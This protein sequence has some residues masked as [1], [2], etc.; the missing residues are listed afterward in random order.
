MPNI[1]P[2]ADE[3]TPSLAQY[4]SWINHTNE[5]PTE[6]QTLA[7]LAFFKWMHE[8]YGMKLDIYAFDAGALDGCKFY[9][10]LESERFKRQFPNGLKPIVDAAASFGCRLGIWGGPDGF[11]D[12]EEEARER[13]QTMVS[14][15]RDHN[16][17]LFKFDSVCGALRPEKVK[18]FIEMMTECRKASPD[19][20]LLNHR[21]ELGEGLPHATTFLWEGMEMYT[22]VHTTNPVPATHNRVGEISRGLPPELKRLTE[23]HGVC[24]SSCVDFWEDSLI[25]QAFNRGLILAP[26]IYG[27]PWL[28][29]DDEFPRLARIYNL[30]HRYRTIL[31]QGQILSKDTY[32]DDAISRGDEKT[33]FLSLRNL[34]WEI[35]ML[36]VT[37]NDSIGLAKGDHVELR[38]MHPFEEVLGTYSWGETIEVRVEPFRACLLI[39]STNNIDEIGF[40]GC[41]GEIICDLPQKDAELILWGEPGTEVK[42]RINAKGYSGAT[43]E[44]EPANDLLKEGLTITFPGQ[45]LNDDYHRKLGDMVSLQI[46]SDH[47]AIYEATCFSADSNAFE[48]RELERSGPTQHPAVQS[49][50]EAFFEQEQ[51]IKRGIWDKNLFDNNP[52]TFFSVCRRYRDVRIRRGALRIDFGKPIHID[53]LTL[54]TRDDYQMQPLRNHEAIM[55]EVSSDLVTWHPIQGFAEGDI[56]FNFNLDQP[57][58]YFRMGPSPDRINEV[59]G[60]LNGKA[61]VRSEWEASNLFSKKFLTEFAWS[62]KVTLDEIHEGS[63][64]VVPVFGPHVPEAVYAGARC[65]GQYLGA[66][67]RAPSYPVNAFEGIARPGEN[68]SYFIPLDKSLEGKSIDVFLLGLDQCASEEIKSEVWVTSHPTPHVKKKVTLLR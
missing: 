62:S 18:Y 45:T 66:A 68:Y 29:R 11:G 59:R 35:K 56:Q 36:P 52:D 22:D 33:R 65:E 64:L 40:E 23:D 63:Y 12:T 49:A 4:F 53:Q 43:F 38:R 57:I 16:F 25:Q 5:G 48:V 6:K 46:P 58:Q 50:R 51:F 67:R 32:G 20:I 17:M 30:H 28:L 26:E 15:C 8:E 27:S 14:L 34:T 55:A 10:S 31:T 13:I 24:I 60:Y 41:S 9:G 39:A 54:H 1:F 21:L 42:A 19:L 44:G 61:L 2:G 47:V 3:S 37:L 7:N